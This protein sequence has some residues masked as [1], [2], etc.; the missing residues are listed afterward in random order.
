MKNSLRYLIKDISGEYVELAEEKAVEFSIPKFEE[1]KEHFLAQHYFKVDNPEHKYQPIVIGMT[2]SDFVEF[3]KYISELTQLPV[4]Y[5]S[6]ENKVSIYG[7]EGG[8]EIITII[9][10][11]K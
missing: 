9:D 6:K 1:T 11:T 5:F 7:T 2:T 10:N 8:I 3:I 4:S